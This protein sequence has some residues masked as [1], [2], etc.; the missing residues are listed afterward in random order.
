MT[1]AYA[2]Q[3]F[4]ISLLQHS[5]VQGGRL[6]LSLPVTQ[7]CDLCEARSPQAMHNVIGNWVRFLMVH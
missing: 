2:E 7:A 6:S 1:F 5:C 3:Q 4:S